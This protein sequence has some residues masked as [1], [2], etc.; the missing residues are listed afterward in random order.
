MLWA[1]NLSLF[2]KF[3][4]QCYRLKF[5]SK[6]LIGKTW[7]EFF[8]FN[9]NEFVVQTGGNYCDFEWNI[10][11]TAEHKWWI[12]PFAGTHQLACSVSISQFFLDFV[13]DHISL[14]SNGRVIGK[15]C[16]HCA[17]WTPN[18]LGWSSGLPCW[19]HCLL[20]WNCW[21]GSLNTR[22]TKFMFY[23][24][25]VFQI[26]GEIRIK[27]FTQVHGLWLSYWIGDV[28]SSMLVTVYCC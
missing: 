13:Y 27:P 10:Q 4:T 3:C 16:S 15:L 6:N 19:I 12:F 22:Y 28:L 17:A 18:F 9:K 24:L 2:L 14:N 11:A 23:W 1:R 20:I 5:C 25:L 26:K 7:N 8:Y 21:K